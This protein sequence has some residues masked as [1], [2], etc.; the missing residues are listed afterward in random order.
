MSITKNKNQHNNNYT[1]IR[2]N[3]PIK[4]FNVQFVRHSEKKPIPCDKSKIYW[5]DE[6]AFWVPLFCIRMKKK[7]HFIIKM[8]KNF[9]ENTPDSYQHRNINIQ[10]H[11]ERKRERQRETQTEK[12]KTLTH[13]ILNQFTVIVIFRYHLFG[14]LFAFIL[15]LVFLV[16]WC[17]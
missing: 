15:A 17:E 7:I 16:C 12:S 1:C 6:L 11:A 14:C 8:H 5:D 2:H 3:V 4:R 9:D 10:T 13:E